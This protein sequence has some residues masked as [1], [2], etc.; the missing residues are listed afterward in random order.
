MNWL[1]EL[2]VESTIE[3][4][5]KLS[6]LESIDEVDTLLDETLQLANRIININVVKDF[7]IFTLKSPHK[8]YTIKQ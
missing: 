3:L 6:K 5:F 4:T 8:D 2:V 1:T 7:N